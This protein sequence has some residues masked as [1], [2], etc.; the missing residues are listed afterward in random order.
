MNCILPL[1]QLNNV[2]GTLSS[3]STHEFILVLQE[4]KLLISQTILDNLFGDS[5]MLV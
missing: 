5:E 4:R 1:G 3:A 2:K